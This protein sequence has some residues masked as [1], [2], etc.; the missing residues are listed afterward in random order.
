MGVNTFTYLF[1]HAHYKKHNFQLRN[2]IHLYQSIV[3]TILSL[4][5]IEDL[6][7]TI[8]FHK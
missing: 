8:N 7:K 1:L 3:A 5:D 6:M 4:L 2:I